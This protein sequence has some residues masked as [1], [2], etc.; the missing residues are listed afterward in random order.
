VIWGTGLISATALVAV[1]VVSLQAPDAAA[2]EQVQRAAPAD[3]ELRDTALAITQAQADFVAALQTQ[4]AVSRGSL[5][6]EAQAFGQSANASWTTYKRYALHRPGEDA[7]GQAYVQANGLGD[8]LGAKLVSLSASSPAFASTLAAQRTAFNGGVDEIAKIESTIYDPILKDGNSAITSDIAATRRV[9]L[10]GFGVLAVLYTII[11]LALMRGARRDQHTLAAEAADLRTGREQ[12]EFDAA[13]QRALEMAATEQ[14]ALGAIQ[15]ALRIVVADTPTELLLADSSYAHFRQVISTHPQCGTACQVG[16]PGEC[17]AARDGHARVFNS[18]EID[19]CPFVEAPEGQVWAVCVPVNVA[20]RTTGV[21]HAQRSTDH[22]HADRLPVDLE[23]VARK[24]G[25]RLGALRVLARTE[26]QAATDPLTG[27]AN[28][29]TLD[30]STHDL[31]ANS[32]PF[33]VAYLDLDHFK[34]INDTFGHDVGDRALRVFARVLRDTVRPGDIVARHGGEE[35]LVVLPECSLGEA[36]S[37]GERIQGELAKA[38]TQGAVPPFTVTI[39]LAASD[40]GETFSEVVSRADAMMLSGKAS[41]RNLIVAGADFARTDDARTDDARADD[42][43]AG[44][45]R[46]DGSKVDGSKVDG[47]KLDRPKGH[48]IKVHA[49]RADE[50]K[51]HEAKVDGPQADGPKADG[52]KPH[53]AQGDAAATNGDR[54]DDAAMAQ[55]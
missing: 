43:T 5:I 42:V 48:T 24:T 12:A 11:A 6:S 27:L 34:E 39:G 25:D 50:A 16:M 8:T 44:D 33:V 52:V 22:P 32:T 45:V 37:V 4:D 31:L 30:A 2:R 36:W 54:A 18:A 13:L 28:R 19:C 46:V 41:G 51:V 10:G 38:L 40:P 29:R 15:K 47:S 26:A 3:L 17:P 7:L 14:S 20:G 35:F 9:I 53:G 49:A 1:T 21:I 23:V 55:S